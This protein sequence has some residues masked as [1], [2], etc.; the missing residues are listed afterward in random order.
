[1]AC[2]NFAFFNEIEK[3]EPPANCGT[4]GPSPAK[5]KEELMAYLRESLPHADR[6]MGER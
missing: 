3:K 6:V 1:M 2:A 4:G 5:T